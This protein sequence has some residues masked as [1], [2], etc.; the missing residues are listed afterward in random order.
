MNTWPTNFYFLHTLLHGINNDVNPHLSS[1]CVWFSNYQE[2]GEERK[3]G[4]GTVIFI[5][6]ANGGPTH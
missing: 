6:G 4:D 5:T 2:I 3:D 1:T